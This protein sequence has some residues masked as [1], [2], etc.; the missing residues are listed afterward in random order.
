MIEAVYDPP[1]VWP[2]LFVE[3]VEDKALCSMPAERCASG[4]PHGDQQQLQHLKEGREVNDL[5]LAV[6]N[7]LALR[8]E[9]ALWSK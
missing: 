6:T 2:F 7:S 5:V 8:A 1:A 4:P 9:P 3:F